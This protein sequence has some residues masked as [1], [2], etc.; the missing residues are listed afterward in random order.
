VDS[1][2]F[3][4]C[5]GSAR[6][7]GWQAVF[8]AYL[9]TADMPGDVQY[10]LSLSNLCYV[11]NA[12]A[13]AEAARGK[14]LLMATDDMFPPEHWD[15]ALLTAIPDLDGEFVAEVSVRTGSWPPASSDPQFMQVL[16]RKRYERYGY[17]FYPEYV[18]MWCDV[19]FTAQAR[20]DGV[21]VDARHVTFDHRHHSLGWVPL[22]DV[23]RRH[24]S[25]ENH[26]IGRELFERRTK[27]GFP[28]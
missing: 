12:N 27:E 23:G 9:D 1:V 11:E 25:A 19:D 10:I 14:V 26:R 28:K 7:K 2:T 8:E 22:D 24:E 5:H 6:P 21:M 18:S 3:S 16:S 17:V 20:K 4:I 15:T 13:A